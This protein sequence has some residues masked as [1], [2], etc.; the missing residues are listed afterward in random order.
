MVS[1]P[2]QPGSIVYLANLLVSSKATEQNQISLKCAYVNDNV[3]QRMG[4]AGKNGLP[5]NTT[6][7]SAWSLKILLLVKERLNFLTV[8]VLE[9]TT[10]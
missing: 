7:A 8:W 5:T 4:P 3:L 1:K 10:K 6:I 9:E 2:T